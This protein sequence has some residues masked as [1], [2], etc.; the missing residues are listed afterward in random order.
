MHSRWTQA[1]FPN[2][3]LRTKIHLVLLALFA[4]MAI[5]GIL[6]GGLLE[7]I[8]SRS[9][10]LIQD[11]QRSIKYTR[12]MSLAMNDLIA[13]LTVDTA[14][15][16]REQYRRINLRKHLDRFETYLRLQESHVSGQGAEVLPLLRSEFERF[17]RTLNESQARQELNIE[18]VMQSF[19]IQGVLR[20][21][22]QANEESIQLRLQEANSMANRATLIM[23]AFG[24]AFFLLAILSM[25]YFPSY[26]LKPIEDMTHSIREIARRNYSLR[27][28]VSSNDELGAMAHSF[29]QMASKLDEYEHMNVQKL[30]SE[31]SRIE[32]IINQMNEAIVGLDGD[33]QI[34][35]ANR[36][37]L[38]LLDWQEEE[39]MGQSAIELAHQSPLF[40]EWILEI[41]NGEA[42]ANR[43]YPSITLQQ[44]GHVYYFEKDVLHVAAGAQETR[45]GFVVILKNV[46]SFKEQEMARTHFIATVSHELKTPISAIDMSMGLLQDHRIGDLN[47]EQRQLTDTVRQNTTRL[48]KMVNELL[49]MSRIEAGQLSLDQDE[50]APAEIVDRALSSISTLFREKGVQGIRQIEPELP[51]LTVDLQ[52]TTGVLINFLTNALRYS[53]KGGKI[54]LQVSLRSGGVC[55]Q[56]RDE[57]PGIEAEDQ[58]RIFQ[59]YQRGKNDR[60]PGTGLGLAISKEFIEKQGGQ[61]WV[62]SK[63][64]QGSTFGFSLPVE[65]KKPVG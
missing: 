13:V 24:F 32:T 63:P 42:Y 43:L 62:E 31:K 21:V 57:G 11:N 37:A 16:D 46:T 56:V 7:R 3:R 23:I 2:I 12:E 54:H 52:K 17:K 10:A 20:Q 9:I 27:L 35:F 64:G 50:V 59:R 65:I 33:L 8:S 19:D 55:F 30:L 40:Q 44:Q 18:L 28:P 14:G 48:L 4:I 25:I 34:L 49:E 61:I 1:W 58:E 38:R 22:Y 15:L 45:Q 53:R 47:G 51:S 5:T 26:I 41:R 60:T 39:V 36:T 6:V 29:N